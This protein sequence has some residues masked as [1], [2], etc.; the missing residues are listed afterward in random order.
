MGA[1]VAVS[2]I[3]VLTYTFLPHAHAPLPTGFKIELAALDGYSTRSA[4]DIAADLKSGRISKFRIDMDRDAH[5]YILLS[6]NS[7]NI[8]KIMEKAVGAGENYLH[9]KMS[10]EFIDGR[11][12]IFLL[13][14]EKRIEDFDKVIRGMKKPPT[15][16]RLEYLF[17]KASVWTL[18]E[19]KKIGRKNK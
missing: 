15:K 14:S 8:E 2:L 4:D 12:E 19:L 3:F 18:G 6:D 9:C 1:S 5:V 13:G 16:D 7:G 17:D 11:N 10:H